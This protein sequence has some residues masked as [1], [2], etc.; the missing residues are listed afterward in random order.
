[1]GSLKGERWVPLAPALLLVVVTGVAAAVYYS[2]EA[3]TFARSSFIQ[4]VSLLPSATVTEPH[5]FIG[6]SIWLTT[7][8]ALVVAL[9][10]AIGSIAVYAVLLKLPRARLFGYGVPILLAASVAAAWRW[11]NA[12]L[13]PAYTKQLVAITSAI[14][15]RAGW[16]LSFHSAL[17]TSC[18]AMAAAFCGAIL[19]RLGEVEVVELRRREQVLRV[20]TYLLAGALV[21]G[22]IQVYA[23]H[24]IPL[25]VM[26]P[27]TGMR[28][29][30]AVVAM[31]NGVLLSAQLLSV[32]GPTVSGL[33]YHVNRRADAHHQ[34][35]SKKRDEW[36]TQQGLQSSWRTDV[37]SLVSLLS[38][39]I[40]SFVGYFLALTHG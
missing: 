6:H 21:F 27:Q 37:S 38:P 20:V 22:V 25:R 36:L 7:E 30:A 8:F 10:A 34:E 18:V 14:D 29:V 2:A 23:F 24:L 9:L 32:V 11:P 26:S 35:D 33:R 28:E 19:V 12:P 5:V 15:P 31:L 1:V 3:G 4:S 16:L 39:A 13:T 17:L 40:A